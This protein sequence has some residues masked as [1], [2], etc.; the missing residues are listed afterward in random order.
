MGWPPR[1][2]D[3]GEI[4]VGIVDSAD[5]PTVG[6]R[7]RVYASGRVIRKA[8][9]ATKGV[10]DGLE[11]TAAVVAA[12]HGTGIDSAARGL[13]RYA[14]ASV[15]RT[16]DGFQP[17][18]LEPKMAAQGVGRGSKLASFRQ[19]VADRPARAT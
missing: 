16:R 5:Q 6:Q 9:R 1:R 10:R 3:R 2:G 14:T 11:V 19:G 17:G 15:V 4:A 18:H 12:R 7:L 13:P 8:I